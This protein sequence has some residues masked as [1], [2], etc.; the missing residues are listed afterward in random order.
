M[1]PS[2]Y[3]ECTYMGRTRAVW[4]CTHRSRVCAGGEELAGLP[5]LLDQLHGE[6]VHLLPAVQVRVLSL[7]LLLLLLRL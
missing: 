6:A 4:P 1:T 2:R 3:T 7:R 5:T